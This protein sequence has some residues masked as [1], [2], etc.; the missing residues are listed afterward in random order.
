MKKGAL[1]SYETTLPIGTTRNRFGNLLEK[2]SGLKVGTD[3]HLVFS[4]ER[5][6]SG[7]IFEDLK[8]CPKIVGGVTAACTEKAVDFYSSAL[9]FTARLGFTRRN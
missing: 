5:V 3:F 4:P 1:I 7:R 2:I 9:T 6:S 8:N